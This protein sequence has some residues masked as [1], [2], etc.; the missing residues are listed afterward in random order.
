MKVKQELL[1]NVTYGS[2]LD[3]LGHTTDMAWVID[4]ADAL[5]SNSF[6]D[7]PAQWLV[8]SFSEA[9]NRD[10]ETNLEASVHSAV[11]KLRLLP[12]GKKIAELSKAQQGCFTLAIAKLVK[13]QVSFGVV[14]DAHIL[15]LTDDNSICHFSD[16]RISA[17]SEK[18]R[19]RP[20][21]EQKHEQMILNRS[22]MNTPDG[23]WAGSIDD[24]WPSQI[25]NFDIPVARCK[26]IL[27]CSDGFY[28]ADDFD[29]IEW[30]D[31]LLERKSL[32]MVYQELRQF[33]SDTQLEHVK[34]HD[35]VSALL[36]IP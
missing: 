31:V 20:T 23:Y 7:S 32:D 6:Q 1:E 36:L 35:D 26:R 11:N 33:E 18:T 14:G 24:N 10:C 15:L 2:Q 28:R 21:T 12:T 4:G 34:Q 3:R 30:Q 5:S 22:Y 27:L 17:F 19:T 16:T 29:L 9:L 13:H 8:D 25:I